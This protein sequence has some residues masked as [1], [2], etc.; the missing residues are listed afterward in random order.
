MAMTVM[1]TAFGSFV[2]RPG[3]DPISPTRDEAGDPS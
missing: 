2:M 1:L 3:F